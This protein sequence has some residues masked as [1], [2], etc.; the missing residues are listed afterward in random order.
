LKMTVQNQL[1][2][3]KYLPD[4]GQPFSIRDWIAEEGDSW[5]FISTREAQMDAIRPLLSLWVYIAIQAVLDLEPIHRERLWFMLDEFPRLQKMDT[6]ELAL[7]NTRK[8]GLCMVLGV[9]DFG[10]LREKYGPNL[11]QTIVSQ[12]QTKAVLRSSDGQAARALAQLLGQAE[13]DEKEETMSYGVNSQR[14][15]VSVST[16]RHLRDIVLSSEILY[17]PDMAG[18]LTTPGPYPIA[19]IQYGYTPRAKIAPSFVPRE[20]VLDPVL[21]P[22]GSESAVKPNRQAGGGAEDGAGEG[23]DIRPFVDAETGVILSEAQVAGL[24]E[25]AQREQLKARVAKSLY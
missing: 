9:Q 6:M 5:M 21:G 10:Q 2:C 14:D 23:V 15:G 24:S 18:Y 1:E 19:K 20:G 22:V 7:T 8:Y 13:M 3:F 12:C 16:R 11:T 25:T 4:V 17:L